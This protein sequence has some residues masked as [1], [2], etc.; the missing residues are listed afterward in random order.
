[1]YFRVFS[2]YF[3]ADMMISAPGNMSCVFLYLVFNLYRTKLLIHLI[4][5]LLLLINLI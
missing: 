4:Y 1:M 5:S 3:Q 2:A